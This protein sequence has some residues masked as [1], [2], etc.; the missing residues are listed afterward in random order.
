M[1]SLFLIISAVVIIATARTPKE[2]K[3]TFKEVDE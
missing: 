2:W 3:D 1:F